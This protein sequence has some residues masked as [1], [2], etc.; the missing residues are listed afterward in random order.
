LKDVNYKKV[1]PAMEASQDDSYS[2]KNGTIEEQTISD[3]M[4]LDNYAVQDMC[5]EDIKKSTREMKYRYCC[6]MS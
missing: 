3:N 5:S 4:Q 1:A 2:M 6:F